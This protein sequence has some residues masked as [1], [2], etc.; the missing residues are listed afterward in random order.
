MRA[1]NAMNLITIFMLFYSVIKMSFTTFMTFSPF[2]NHKTKPRN[3]AQLI[4]NHTVEPGDSRLL[5][6]N[7]KIE[8]R[9]L[10]HLFFSS[11]TTKNCDSDQIFCH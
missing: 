8:V 6:F 5:F 4:F 1:Y 9:S 10:E 3:H 11:H 2:F 7:H